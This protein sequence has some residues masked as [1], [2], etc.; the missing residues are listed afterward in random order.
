MAKQTKKQTR[1]SS[2]TRTATPKAAPR[3]AVKLHDVAGYPSWTI[4]SDDVQLSLARRGGHMAPVTFFRQSAKF[5]PMAIAPW[6]LDVKAKYA[7]NHLSLLR[8]DFFCMPFGGNAEPYGKE[9]HQGHGETAN[10]DWKL[11][12][13]GKAVADIEDG[14]DDTYTYLVAEMRTKTRKAKIEKLIALRDGEE[15]VY[16]CH[17]ISGMAGPMP[18]G[19][20]AMLQWKRQGAGLISVSK[21]T[22]G[23]VFPGMFE[24]PAEGGYQSL[25]PGATFTSLSKVPMLDGGNA[26]LSVYPARL[27]FEDLVMVCSDRKG[28]FAWSAAVYPDDRMVWFALKDPAKLAST[29]L[30]HSNRGRHYYP[31]NGR[32]VGVLGIE[33]VTSY[34][35]CGI[36]PSVKANP[37]SRKGIP[38]CR[39]FKAGETFAV[40]YVMAAAKIPAGF[41][42]VKSIE[43]IADDVVELV[44]KSGK[45]V[46]SRVGWSFVGPDE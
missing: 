26:D 7:V 39:T 28:P 8:G 9:K 17:E 46:K 34:F 29:V 4:A 11:T 25:K 24:N 41:D 12:D 38:T 3:S 19:H 1:K 43:P 45:K 20:H 13:A 10:S 2:A 27:G 5:S 15:A 36:E 44:S 40:P 18:Y 31:W 16:I 32:H 42:H 14:G 30:W 6:S 35:H 21:F 37:I 23:Q 33:E 22:H